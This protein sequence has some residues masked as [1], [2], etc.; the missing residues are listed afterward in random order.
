[1]TSILVLEIHVHFRFGEKW[2]EDRPATF[3]HG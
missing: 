3:K 2:C 1:M